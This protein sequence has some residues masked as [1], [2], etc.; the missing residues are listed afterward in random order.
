[1]NPSHTPETTATLRRAFASRSAVASTSAPAV[2]ATAAADTA[3]RST[4]GADTPQIL[5]RFHFE[6]TA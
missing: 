3:Q 5:D 1:M 2:Q 4:R 6:V